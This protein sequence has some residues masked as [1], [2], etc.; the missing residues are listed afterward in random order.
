MTVSDDFLPG[1]PNYDSGPNYPV[2]FGIT[3]TPL[4]GGVLLALAGLGIATW[5]LLTLVQPEWEKYQSLDAKVR[6]KNDQIAQQEATIK[7]SEKVKAELATAKKQRQDV[8]ALFANESTFDTLLLDLN[9]QIE[10]RNAGYT[11]RRQDKLASCPAWVRSNVKEVEDQ[12][13]DLVAKA[14][15]KRFEPNSKTSGIITDGSYGSQVNNKLKR[16]TVTVELEGNFNQTQAIMRSI[17]RLQPLLVL[18]D[19]DFTL[20]ESGKTKR[21]TTIYSQQGNT[22]RPDPRCQPEPKITSRFQLEALMPLTAAETA[23]ANPTPPAQK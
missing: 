21:F 6:E 1:D 22:Y 19:A 13:G 10:T 11:K 8:L 18:K 16:E 3:I 14:R 9:R 5:V 23:T 15:L 20:G 12:V 2:V 4:I 7:Q 17:E